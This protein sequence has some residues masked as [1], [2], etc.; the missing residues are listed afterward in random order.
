MDEKVTQYVH[1]ME[2]YAAL[3]NDTVAPYIPMWKEIC[4]TY[5]KLKT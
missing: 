5:L 4:D 2:H 3:K 1:S